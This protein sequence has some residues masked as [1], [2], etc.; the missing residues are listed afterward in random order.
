MKTKKSIRTYKTLKLF[1]Y[2]HPRNT[3]QSQHNL[4]VEIECNKQLYEVNKKAFK[5][6]SLDSILFDNYLRNNYSNSKMINPLRRFLIYLDESI[7]KRSI[8]DVCKP[9]YIHT[10]KLLIQ[11]SLDSRTYLG[12]K[13]NRNKPKPIKVGTYIL[14]WSEFKS[15]I[16]KA[17]PL[18]IDDYP[19]Y[20]GCLKKP[21]NS[22]LS[23]SHII[24]RNE[25]LKILWN[26]PVFENSKRRKSNKGEI[27]VKEACFFCLYTGLRMIDIINLE[28]ESITKVDSNIWLV[29]VIQLKTGNKVANTFPLFARKLL[30]Q[31][32]N[33]DSRIF[34]DLQGFDYLNSY[35]QLTY[36]RFVRWRNR[37]GVSKEKTLHTFRHTYANNLYKQCG[38][39]Y[40]VSRALGHSKLETTLSFYAPAEVRTNENAKHIEKAYNF[41]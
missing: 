1:K 28:W 29:K 25:E 23:K 24:Y 26:T 20:I 8:Q 31:R 19:N 18:Y 14:Y 22:V 10:L 11:K 9:K 12:F 34:D 2:K 5:T 32:K 16:R 4:N 21:K 30:G 6:S 36:D 15:L 37:A 41:L 35:R 27:G 40:E 38:N 33:Q 39:I 17:Y 3:K 13:G 7:I